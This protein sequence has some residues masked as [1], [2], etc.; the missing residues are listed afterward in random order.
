MKKPEP[1]TKAICNS[2]R[3]RELGLLDDFL[4]VVPTEKG[5]PSNPL[6]HLA[7]NVTAN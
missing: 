4:S 6:L 2:G 5:L 7:P 3:S 1:L